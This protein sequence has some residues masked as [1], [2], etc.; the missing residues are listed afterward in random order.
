MQWNESDSMFANIVSFDQAKWIS[1]TFDNE[2]VEN[3]IY[4]FDTFGFWMFY[5][6]LQ[7][8]KSISLFGILLDNCQ[9]MIML[10]I[11]N[12]E[13]IRAKTDVEIFWHSIRL[14]FNLKSKFSTPQSPNM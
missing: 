9:Q 6:L 12:K 4:I 2:W 8:N 10:L 7:I 1:L 14:S 5:T 11:C 3:V 13:I